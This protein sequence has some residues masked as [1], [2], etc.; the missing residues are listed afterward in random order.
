M[1]ASFEEDGGA[2]TRTAVAQQTEGAIRIQ[3][4]ITT[5]VSVLFFPKSIHRQNSPEFV[6]FLLALLFMLDSLIFVL[7]R[8][9]RYSGVNLF[10]VVVLRACMLQPKQPE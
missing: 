3:V 10:V 7:H 4:R 5:L 8:N 1:G 9:E 2:C 6:I